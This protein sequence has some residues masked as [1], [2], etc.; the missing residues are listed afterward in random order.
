MKRRIWVISGKQGSGKST[1]AA[2]LIKH[3][4]PNAVVIKFADPLYAIHDACLPV[5]KKFG[6]RPEEMKKD[7]EL[8]QILGTEYGRRFLGDDV[9]VNAARA[10]AEMWLN[11]SD[12]NVV[13]IDDCR[14]ENEFD[15]FMND[16]YLIRL[17]CPREIRKA[18]CGYWRD[19]ED[20]VSET[21]LDQYEQQY[22][23][24]ASIDTSK[25]RDGR[26]LEEL[27]RIF[28]SFYE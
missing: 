26:S 2:E 16:A 1:F 15:T 19:N 25:A 17:K 12:K 28:G 18:R 8:L 7:G 11:A 14:F 5:L 3:F 24:H 21:G 10:R 27:M 23:F 13:I 9:W 20:H 22:R 4:S 6:L